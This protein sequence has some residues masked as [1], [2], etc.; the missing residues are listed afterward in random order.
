[1]WSSLVGNQG[2]AANLRAYVEALPGDS[3]MAFNQQT[4]ATLQGKAIPMRME[5][6]NPIGLFSGEIKKAGKLRRYRLNSERLAESRGADGMA[7]LAR[8]DPGTREAR[9]LFGAIL[10]LT[11]T[12]SDQR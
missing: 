6:L 3:A 8:L 9:R 5:D 2:K 7:Q 4:V 10:G 1:M 11:A 12:E